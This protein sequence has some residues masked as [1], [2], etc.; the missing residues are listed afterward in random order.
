MKNKKCHT[1]QTVPKSNTKIEE[2]GKF[3]TVAHIYMTS[4]F[5]GLIKALTGGVNETSSL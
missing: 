5:H 1:V 3:D 2:R 4:H